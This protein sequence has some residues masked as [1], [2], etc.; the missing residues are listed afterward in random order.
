M[1][2][3]ENTTG[4]DGGI[5]KESVELLVVSNGEL[6]VSGDDSGLLGVL[7]GVTGELEDLSGEVLKDGSEVHWGTSSDSLGVSSLLQVAGDSADWELKSGLGGTRDRLLLVA[8]RSLGTLGA[9]GSLSGH[10]VLLVLGIWVEWF[11]APTRSGRQLLFAFCQLSLRFLTLLSGC[12][13]GSPVD[14]GI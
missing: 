2:V 3:R 13:S 14:H 1:D 10:R 9:L 11:R 5:L 8:H 6:D 12:E 7:G 4:G